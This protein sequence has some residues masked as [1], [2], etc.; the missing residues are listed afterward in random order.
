MCR[1]SGR[2][3]QSAPE[4]CSATRARQNTLSSRVAGCRSALRHGTAS[5]APARHSR[6]PSP[7]GGTCCLRDLQ[8]SVSALNM[9]SSREAGCRSIAAPRRRQQRTRQAQQ[10]AQN[11]SRTHN[12][13]FKF[14][15]GKRAAW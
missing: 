12:N 3:S 7:A 14:H 5:S 11:R 1:N 9:L 8:C 4:T 6:N 2:T 10:N 15:T 13:A